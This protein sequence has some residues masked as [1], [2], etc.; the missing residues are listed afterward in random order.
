MFFAYLKLIISFVH[1][2]AGMRMERKSYGLNGEPVAYRLIGNR[3]VKYIINFIAVIATAWVIYSIGSMIYKMQ[4]NIGDMR[5]EYA[6][7]KNNFE[8]ADQ[9]N[10]VYKDRS[11]KLLTENRQLAE[12]LRSTTDLALRLDGKY[13]TL[14]ADLLR[15]NNEYKAAL[16]RERKLQRVIEEEASRREAFRQKAL[17][18]MMEINERINT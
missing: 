11:E 3:A 13:Q 7:L 9:L 17:E 15:L 18:A 16:E 5:T 8:S 10:T 14:E 1:F 6:L 2:I 4:D 12:D